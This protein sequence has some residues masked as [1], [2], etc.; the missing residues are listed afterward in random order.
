MNSLL[1]IQSSDVQSGLHF[2]ELEDLHR[3]LDPPA[4]VPTQSYSEKVT[5]C[6]PLIYVHGRKF[7]IAAH[8]QSDGVKYQHFVT[9]VG[10]CYRCIRYLLASTRDH[11]ELP[12]M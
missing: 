3:P 11:F 8:S 6:N 1:G 4:P 7:S 2:T 5:K 10:I 9:A 12:P